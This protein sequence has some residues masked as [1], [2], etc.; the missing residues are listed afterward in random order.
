MRN[1]ALSPFISATLILIIGIIAISLVLSVIKPSL[2]KARDSV[3]IDE[4]FRNLNLIDDT[5]REV[6]SE[7]EDSKRTILLRITE[8]KYLVDSD[9]DCINFTY[10]MKTGL[11]ISGQRNGINITRTGNTINLFISYAK[12]D[13]QGSD[14]FTK[15]DNSAVVSHEGIDSITNYPIICVGK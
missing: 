1:R 5:I 10:D 4:A 3:V 14:H 7:G 2:D 15:G 12:V 11:D 9:C 6:V 8:G 13:V